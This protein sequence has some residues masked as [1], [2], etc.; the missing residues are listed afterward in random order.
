MQTQKPKFSWHYYV[1]AFGALMAL[2]AA[3]LSA[4]GAVMSAVGFAVIAHPV[5]PFKGLTRF[6][7]FVLFAVLF[8]LGFPDAAVVQEMMAKDVS[9]A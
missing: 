2:L 6:V 8:V 9:Q 1:M 3:T 5:L 7:F 4:W